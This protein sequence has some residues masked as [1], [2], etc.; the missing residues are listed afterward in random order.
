MKLRSGLP[1]AALALALG[2][3]ACGSTAAKTAASSPS[4]T[5][6]TRAR[7]RGANGVAGTVAS[8]NG[9]TLIVN[10]RAGGSAT[11]DTSPS[12]VVMKTVTTTVSALAPNTTVLVTGPLNADGTYTANAITITP[13]GG[14]G[15]FG[16]FGGG[17]G[18]GFGGFGGGAFTPRPR[19][20][21]GVGA[22]RA[23]GAVGTVTSVKGADVYLQTAAGASIEAITSPGTVVS[24]TQA[25]ALSD[26]TAGTTVTV[27]GPQGSD[28][29][30]SATRI[31]IG[32]LGLN[33][34]LGGGFFGGGGG[35]AGGGTGAA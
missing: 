22:G 2:A 19:A 5:P 8:V 23:R 20:S 14:A 25:G 16:G 35:T 30:Y 29:A 4:P 28:G 11:V 26:V 13:L 27:V 6:T 21:G 18:G 9:S 24:E 7:G 32:N 15:G 17:G 1:L 34:G 31:I 10:L 33:L 12:T 3:V